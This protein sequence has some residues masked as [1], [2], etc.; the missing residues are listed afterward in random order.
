MELRKLPAPSGSTQQT[1]AQVLDIDLDR[2]DDFV[3][4]TRLSPGPALVWYRL[5][6][7]GWKKCLIEAELLPIEVD[8]A[9]S[10]IDGDMPVNS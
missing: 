7:N 9:F 3:I 10:D 8:G 6:D 1:V 4:G 2:K 5:E